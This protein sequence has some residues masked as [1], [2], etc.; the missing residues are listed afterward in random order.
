MRS[1]NSYFETVIFTDDELLSNLTDIGINSRPKLND[2]DENEKDN[3]NNAFFEDSSIINNDRVNESDELSQFE[4]DEERYERSRY[5]RQLLASFDRC[6][7]FI[8]NIALVDA[9]KIVEINKD[10]N[11]FIPYINF[12]RNIRDTLKQNMKD[13]LKSRYNYDVSEDDYELAID[14]ELPEW[15]YLTSVGFDEDS[16]DNYDSYMWDD[17]HENYEYEDNGCNCEG[18]DD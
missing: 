1:N 2:L 11:I 18:T 13:D 8:M 16:D 12:A 6:Y 7:R 10:N 9:N 4:I 5:W 14:E 3:I 17:E 15:E